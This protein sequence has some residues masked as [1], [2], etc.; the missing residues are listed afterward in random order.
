LHHWPFKPAGEPSSIR[1]REAAK[2]NIL[3]AWTQHERL[4]KAAN[5]PAERANSVSLALHPVGDIHQPLH[6]AQL[7]TGWAVSPAGYAA[8]AGD[9]AERRIFVAGYK[10]ADIMRRM[11][12]K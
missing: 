5:A 2:E 10:L 6:T 1:V 8:N 12:R 9:I 4:M 3:T 7:F 11:L